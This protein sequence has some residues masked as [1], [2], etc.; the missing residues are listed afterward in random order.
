LTD[1]IPA[2]RGDFEKKKLA[3][4]AVV[5]DN[6]LSIRKNMSF[7]EFASTCR[8]M[9]LQLSEVEKDE[10]QTAALRSKFC[11]KMSYF[12]GGRGSALL[13]DRSTFKDFIESASTGKGQICVA[14]ASPLS[15]AEGGAAYSGEL[16]G[17]LARKRPHE[18]SIG[19]RTISC[20]F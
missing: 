6:I 17:K 3:L 15:S 5:G 8:N 9:L 18:W 7:A 13:L 2:V 19:L 4:R 16:Q 14:F 1:E 11:P 10:A 20:I 12:V